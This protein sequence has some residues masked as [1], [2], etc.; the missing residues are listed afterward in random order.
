MG[1]IVTGTLAYQWYTQANLAIEIKKAAKTN[2]AKGRSSITRAWTNLLDAQFE[3]TRAEENLA[4][5]Q[6]AEALAKE[7]TERA[8][9]NFEAV[10]YLLAANEVQALTEKTTSLQVGTHANDELTVLLGIEALRLGN[11]LAEEDSS[12]ASRANAALRNVLRSK[13]FSKVLDQDD[14]FINEIAVLPRPS[15]GHAGSDNALRLYD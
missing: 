4:I 13:D 2:E 6:A 7:Q 14:M 10:R 11:E 9:R 5:A 15:P 8:D 1:I 3:R 12:L